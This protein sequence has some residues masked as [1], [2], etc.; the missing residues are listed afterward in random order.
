M[1]RIGWC[2]VAIV[3]MGFA[4]GGCQSYEDGIKA[5]CEAPNH[6]EK[7]AKVAPDARGRLLAQQVEKD[8]SNGKAESFFESLGYMEPAERLTK[9]REEASSAGLT[10]CPLADK[11][12]E[13]DKM[14]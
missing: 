8:T 11:W 4:L 10:D 13:L 12:E 5:I 3:A 2:G 14:P 9:L 7:C 6:C 1:E